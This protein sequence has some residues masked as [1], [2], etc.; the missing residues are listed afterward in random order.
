MKFDIVLQN[1][2]QNLSFALKTTEIEI[3]KAEGVEIMLN[4]KNKQIGAVFYGIWL[5][6]HQ[7]YNAI[8]HWKNS[9]DSF[10]LQTDVFSLEVFVKSPPNKESLVG[11]KI[12]KDAGN[13]LKDFPT[14][15]IT[16]FA[17]PYAEVEKLIA[18]FNE[19]ARSTTARPY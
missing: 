13:L 7:I 4:F 9:Q 15:L 16:N 5:E 8:E 14:T 3:D 10:S 1:N 6:H 19:L 2:E 11:L 12:T 17:L 18:Y